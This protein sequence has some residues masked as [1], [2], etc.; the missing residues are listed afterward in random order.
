MA[1]GGRRQHAGQIDAPQAAAAGPWRPTKYPAPAQT[2]D[3]AR[4]AYTMLTP[5]LRRYGT[6]RFLLL[7]LVTGGVKCNV[8]TITRIG[9][10]Q[11]TR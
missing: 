1:T 7:L 2:I 3:I 9:D 5:F 11:D 4:N 10:E 8:Q 6:Q